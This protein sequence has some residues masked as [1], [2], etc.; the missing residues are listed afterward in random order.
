MA[1]PFLGSEEYDERAH[2]LYNSGDYDSALDTLKEGL[3]RYPHSVDLHVGLGYTRLAREEFVWAKQSFE[4][5]LA[6]DPEHED[7]LVGLG[8]ALLRFGR[9]EEALECFERVRRAG[10]GDDLDLLLSM[11]RA[12]YREQLYEEAHDIFRE[13][14]LLHTDNPEAV[15]G[16]A[17]TLHRLGQEGAA[18]RELRRAL[19]LDPAF[20][21]ARIYL[22]HL[23]YDRGDWKGALRQY[24]RVPPSEQWDSLA[25]WRLL[26]LKRTLGGVPAGDPDLAAWESRLEML[27]ARTDPV[28]ALL[29]EIEH[30]AAEAIGATAEPGDRWAAEPIH[31]VRTR[32][33]QVYTGTW[34]EIVRQIRDAMGQPDE[35]VAQFMRRWAEDHRARTGEGIPG[36]DPEAFLRAG[37]RAGYLRIE[38]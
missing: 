32:D 15:A 13:A 28:E 3:A 9:Q 2:R 30:G 37:E 6:L 19:K 10:C 29:A 27:E 24:E 36:D 14:T 7:A 26:E 17:Y 35:T 16:L 34:I 22:G 11:G 8:E 25:L 4:A 12:L 31:R 23:L 5:A 33:G 20:H 18:R 1:T 21:E 38:C